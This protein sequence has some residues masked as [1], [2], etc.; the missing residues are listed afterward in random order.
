MSAEERR[1]VVTKGIDEAERKVSWFGLIRDDAT[2][3]VVFR[4]LFPDSHFADGIKMITAW[5]KPVGTMFGTSVE[6]W[7]C[8]PTACVQWYPGPGNNDVL[9][10]LCSEH[11][12]L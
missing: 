10:Q 1:T 12:K 6:V 4:Y 11:F 7:I 3:R 8:G 9:M 5:G 2:G